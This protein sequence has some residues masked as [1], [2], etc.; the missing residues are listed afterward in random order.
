MSARLGRE[1]SYS[2]HEA[3]HSVLQM[4]SGGQGE[5]SSEENHSSLESKQTIER[6]IELIDRAQT[7]TSFDQ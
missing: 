6:A 5:S 4:T 7:R 3:V 1:V 2:D